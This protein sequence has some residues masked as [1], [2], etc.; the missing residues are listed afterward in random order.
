MAAERSVLV[1]LPPVQWGG[2]QTFAA[3]LSAGLKQAG[4]RW[5]VVIPPEAPEI[6]QR[7]R[8]AGV[9]V[10][11]APLLRFRRSPLLTLKALTGMAGN[12]QS[13]SALEQVRQAS[14][15]QAVGAHH[16]HGP[17][18]AKKLGKPLVW[19]IHSS[20]LPAPIRKLVA[21]CITRHADAIMTNGLAV[22]NDFWSKE[23]LA[24]PHFVFYAPVDTERYAPN[25]E[26]RAA[27]RRELGYEDDTVVVGTVGNQVWQKNHALLVAVA[28]EVAPLY[29]K[30]RFLVLGAEHDAYH[31]EYE[32]TVK[33]PAAIL[34]Q[35]F[36]GYIRFLDPGR[37]VHCWVHALDVF[38][39]TSQA[40]G[41]PIALFEAMS[42]EKAVV[43]TRAGSI[44]EV[45][46]EGC[47]GFVCERGDGGALAA[48]LRE[49]AQNHSLRANMGK[50]GRRRILEK[51]SLRQVVEAHVNA[52]EAAIEAHAR[53]K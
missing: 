38:T 34:N 33:Q 4:W 36:P 29:P 9:E 42:A 40:E 32:A 25:P 22:A 21:P 45:V 3:N 48:R 37:E 51:F 17:M 43:S 1:P 23:R 18:L 14:L 49:L 13:L 26:A 27:A 16:F 31:A 35:Q 11:S 53:R 50:A 15:V 46:E 2:L 24:P 52:Y 7:L 44:A 30:L 47:S 19:Q 5:T 39:L 8:E 10:V 6:Q 20:I 12:V 41:V 28:G